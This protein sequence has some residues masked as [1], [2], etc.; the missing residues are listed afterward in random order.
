MPFIND[1]VLIKT[2][3][4]IL[5]ELFSHSNSDV[6]PVIQFSG[7][8]SNLEILVENLVHDWPELAG[9]I[10]ADTPNAFHFHIFLLGSDTMAENPLD[11]VREKFEGSLKEF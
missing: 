3:R 10:C 1:Y 5:F 9:K 8:S 11:F 6:I 2:G 4:R 7:G